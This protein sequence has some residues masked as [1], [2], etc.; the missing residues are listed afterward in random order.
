[1]KNT[2]DNN[3]NNGFSCYSSPD[4]KQNLKE[5]EN[6]FLPE[7]SFKLSLKGLQDGVRPWSRIRQHTG[8][9]TGLLH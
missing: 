1:M 8:P 2:D 7:E 9:T 5:G 3:T 6:V 4:W